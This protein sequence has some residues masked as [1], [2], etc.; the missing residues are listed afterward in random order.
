[1]PAIARK[2]KAAPSPGAFEVTTEFPHLGLHW[3]AS[4]GDV[5]LVTYA[6]QNGQPVNS[7]IDGVLPLHAACSSGDDGVVQLLIDHGADVNAPRCVPA[8]F[9]SSL[10]Q[11][12][13]FFRSLLSTGYP[14]DTQMIRPARQHLRRL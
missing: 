12:L 2:A 8:S 3:A 11:A 14:A 7:V 13:I 4:T 9:S 1:M 5:G 10:F 6:L